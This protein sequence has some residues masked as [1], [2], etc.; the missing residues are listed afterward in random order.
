MK[1]IITFLRELQANNNREWFMANKARYTA[2]QAQFN[3][4]VDVLIHEISKFDSSVTGLM[5]KDCT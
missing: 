1:E 3:N 2:L 4:F 5:A